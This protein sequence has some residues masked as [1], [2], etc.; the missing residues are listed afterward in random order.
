MRKS[1]LVLLAVALLTTA[2]RGQ[3]PS[4]GA[5]A[6]TNQE[7][8][9]SVPHSP[10]KLVASIGQVM[11]LITIP[12]SD[13]IF[14]AA[15]KTPKNDTAWQDVQNSALL[16]A[17]SGNLMMIPGR[18]PD[19]QE[20]IRQSQAMIDAAM[21]AFNAAAAKDSDQLSDAGDKIYNTCDAC[22]NKYM[23]KGR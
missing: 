9:A 5:S 1:V 7:R 13:V 11:T 10:F 2:L 17:E 6:K 14:D 8:A 4:T 23:D 21:L 15:A 3:Q 19:N 12:A 20:W 16:L 18:A 22:H